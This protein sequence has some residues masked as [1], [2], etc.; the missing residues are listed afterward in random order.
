MREVARPARGPRCF[1]STSR[2]CSACRVIANPDHAHSVQSGTA[3]AGHRAVRGNENSVRSPSPP[4]VS[5]S[6]STL[7]PVISGFITGHLSGS[8]MQLINLLI[9]AM[10]YL[11][12]MHRI[13]STAPREIATDANRHHLAKQREACGELS[14]PGEWR[15]EGVTESASALAAGKPVAAAVVD[16]AAAVED[17]L[18]YKSVGYGGLP[19]RKWRGGNG[20]RHGRRHAG[21]WRREIWWISPTRY[22]WRSVAASAITACWS[23]R[24]HASGH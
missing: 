18:F 3:G 1:T 15:L 17:F 16:A 12:F 5:R 13:N 2:F 20:R 24:A 6:L 21:V 7:P 23:A 9:G 4:G 10:L 8:I 11:P 14:P 19:N 22:A